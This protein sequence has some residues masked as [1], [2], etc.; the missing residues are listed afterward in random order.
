M[1][2][3]KTLVTKPQRFSFSED[4]RTGKLKY[5]FNFDQ[6]YEKAF[7]LK[8]DEDLVRKIID[9]YIHDGYKFDEVVFW[10][11]AKREKFISQKLSKE[12][13]LGLDLHHFVMSS[14]SFRKVGV[15]N[16]D[17]LVGTSGPRM[18]I[19]LNEVEFAQVR[20]LTGDYFNYRFT[21][22][23]AGKVFPKCEYF[24]TVPL[25]NIITFSFVEEFEF[26]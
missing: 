7:L 4:L 26:H 15:W 19:R 14:D 18:T 8:R 11:Q 20:L 6:S 10:G 12:N 25:T 5:N 22:R 21:D 23:F 13:S 3:T 24:I 9:D 16:V 17:K 2:T 1:S